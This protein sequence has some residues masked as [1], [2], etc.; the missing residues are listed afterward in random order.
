MATLNERSESREYG[1]DGSITLVYDYRDAGTDTN[2][3]Y[4]AL[5]ATLPEKAQ[6][7]DGKQALRESHP[8]MDAVYVDTVSDR[9]DYLVRCRYA[10]PE[11]ARLAEEEVTVRISSQGGSRHITQS[12]STPHRYL[13]PGWPGEAPNY[14]GAIG[15]V[16][17]EPPAG[18]DVSDPIEV[19]VITRRFTV[20]NLPLTGTL[21][22]I[23]GKVNSDEV[24]IKDTRKNRTWIAAAGELRCDGFDEG[25]LDDDG[26]VTVTFNMALSPNLTEITIGDIADIEKLGHDY[27][28]VDYWTEID[29]NGY[30]I[31][32]PFSVYVENVY[33]R[34]AMNGLDLDG[35]TPE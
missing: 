28:W 11:T 12:Y 31:S 10:P 26:L 18:T 2:A 14:Y 32:W 27:L 21:I 25:T 20:A 29:G 1:A 3:A 7:Y 5:L 24:T 19:M 34:A 6:T 8:S 35:E 33:V 30:Q 23:T 13:D 15:V 9:G 22:A 4:D 16:R 17:G